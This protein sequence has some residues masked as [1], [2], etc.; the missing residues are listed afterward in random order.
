MH[1][2]Q[3]L[4]IESG[5]EAK[6]LGQG[7]AFLHMQN[8]SIKQMMIEVILCATGTYWWGHANAG[9]LQLRRNDVRL[10]RLPEAFDGFT[11]LHLSDLHA[12]MSAS[13]LERVAESGEIAKLNR[14]RLNS[15]GCRSPARS[16]RRDPRPDTA[17][18]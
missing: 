14:P 2:R 12:D 5:H 7:F 18:G 16:P 13:A 8:M 1:A 15:P 3:R 4:A 11:I 6:A 10:P 9:K 17:S